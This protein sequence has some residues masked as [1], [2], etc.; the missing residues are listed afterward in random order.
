MM[1][2]GGAFNSPEFREFSKQVVPFLHVTS[3]IEGRAD[4]DLLSRKAQRV[5]FPTILILDAEGEPLVTLDRARLS[6][7]LGTG[8]EPVPSWRKQLSACERYVALRAK[9]AAGDASVKVDLAVAALTIGKLSFGQFDVEVAGVTLTAEQEQAIGQVRAN[10]ICEE[11]SA[12][13]RSRGQDPATDKAATEAFA[14]LF[15]A[16]THPDSD[17]SYMYWWVIATHGLATHDRAMLERSLEALEAT[18][19][20]GRWGD[21]VDRMK[22]E[23]RKLGPAAPPGRPS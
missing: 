1:L 23:L 5:V 7:A 15:A 14:K 16:G 22:A 4:D 9:A 18:G 19:G 10:A 20:P 8:V 17:S 11:I 6:S 2:E 12:R 13:M 3:H 21:I